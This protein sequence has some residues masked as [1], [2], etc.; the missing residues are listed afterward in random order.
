MAPNSCIF[1]Y[2]FVP[3]MKHHSS[4]KPYGIFRPGIFSI[5]SFVIHHD[6]TALYW[7]HKHHDCMEN[8]IEHY[9][10]LV[11]RA[12][13]RHADGECGKNVLLT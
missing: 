9:K 8:P 10:Q 12:Y 6:Y 7:A 1:Q 4:S 11:S 3:L 5:P 2:H 13:L